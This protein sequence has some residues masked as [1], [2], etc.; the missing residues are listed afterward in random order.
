M[1]VQFIQSGMADSQIACNS[2]RKN[3][4]CSKLI[5][6]QSFYGLERNILLTGVVCLITTIYN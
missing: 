6:L 1:L 5:L 2:I 4:Y 3:V